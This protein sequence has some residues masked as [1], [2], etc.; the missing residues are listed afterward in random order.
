MSS[1]QAIRMRHSSGHEIQESGFN[2][3]PIISFERNFNEEEFFQWINQ[4][5]SLSVWYSAVYL[6]IIFGGKYYMQKRP[7][8]E[9]RP[10][11]ALWSAILGAFSIFGAIRTIPETFYVIHNHGW[12]YSVCIPSYTIGPTA[13]WTFLFTI[14]K[15]YELGDTIFII[16]RKQP[17][18]FLHWYHHVT[19][20]I[21]TWYSY[22]EH[23]GPGRWFIMMNYT[24]HSVMY[25]YYTLRALRISV[26]KF[27]AMTITT[28]QILQ[29]IVFSS[30]IVAEG[31]GTL[32]TSL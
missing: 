21:Y 8:F 28:M 16:L 13:F 20:L 3:T 23:L 25:S 18:I 6:V 30:I 9:I 19:V 22:P 14:S 24:V 17:L 15:V 11:L 27:V 7:R 10:A 1:I 26:P 4:N 12:Q 5:W 2:Q 29:V 32:M 31:S